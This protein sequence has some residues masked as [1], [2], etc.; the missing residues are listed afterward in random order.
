MASSITKRAA[1]HRS[2][3]AMSI[4]AVSLGACTTNKR[5]GPV[6][7]D[8]QNFG[9]P[10]ALP[11]STA[12]TQYH[13]APGDTLSVSVYK[14]PDL[15]RDVEVDAAGGFIYPPLGRIDANNRTV[16]DLGKELQTRLGENYLQSPT[17]LVTLKSTIANQITVDGSVTS[18]GMY[19][20]PPGTTLL[21]A[22]AI[23]K[24]PAKDANLRRVVVF[25]QVSGQRM[26]AAFDLVDI[27]RGTAPDPE[28]Y[29]RDIIVVDGSETR[30][31]MTDV[32][33]TLPLLSI[34]RP[35]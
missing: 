14:V 26:A 11:L 5:G 9:A 15:T 28:V 2:L 25:R 16:A 24:G 7:Y 29:S 12:A 13:I 35:F 21:Q 8:V 3:V 27:R 4:I 18:P 19:P 6:P 31:R 34:F 33:Q 23:A 1:A 22:L 30:Q 17:V 32:L 10:E 20:I